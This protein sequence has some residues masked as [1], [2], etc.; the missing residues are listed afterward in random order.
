MG[1]ELWAQDGAD[2]IELLWFSHTAWLKPESKFS[3]YVFFHTPVFIKVS[4]MKPYPELPRMLF[5]STNSDLGS[6]HFSLKNWTLATYV[7]ISS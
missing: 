5:K 2:K 4:S 6:A 3:L 7:L 1:A